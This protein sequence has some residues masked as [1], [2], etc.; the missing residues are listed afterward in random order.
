MA[1]QPIV[2]ARDGKLF[3]RE[4][5]VRTRE[6]SL[7]YPGAL[8]DAAERLSRVSELSQAIRD[9]VGQSIESSALGGTIF[10]NLHTLDLNDDALLSPDAPLSRHAPS[11]VLEVAESAP[12]HR[13]AD[14]R[15]RVRGMRELGYRI[16]LDD[17][18]AGYA[19]LTSFTA[20][21][22]DVVK[23]DMTL[24]R[25]VDTQLIK[26]KLIASM[27][28]LCKELGIRVVAEGVETPGE[29]DVLVDLGCDLLQGYL[30]GRPAPLPPLL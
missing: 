9:D 7:M 25:D 1:Y 6:D 29:R 15:Q 2:T 19:G 23:L 13:I 22:P 12:L 24:V 21:E 4:A 30:F 28:G 18:G 5:L 16:A 20:L 10:V 11:I 14:L 17:L 8:F 27:V 3:A 26:R